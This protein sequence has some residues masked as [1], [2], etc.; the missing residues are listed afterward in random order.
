MLPRVDF[1]IYASYPF[2]IDLVSVQDAS[3]EEEGEFDED[4]EAL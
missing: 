1:A 4:D 2:Q 3:A